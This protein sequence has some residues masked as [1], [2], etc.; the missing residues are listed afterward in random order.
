M[1]SLIDTNVVLDALLGRKPFAKYAAAIFALAER[2]RIEAFL[3]PTTV[4]TIDYFMER[5]L[6]T[7]EARK[8]IGRLLKIFE[9]APVNRSVLERALALKMRDYEDAVLIA[10]AELVGAEVIVTRNVKDFV[11]SPL[12]IFQPDEFLAALNG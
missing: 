2:S 6:P 10:S 4:T 11:R 1:R 9:I 7:P 12:R 8:A 3:C 5:S